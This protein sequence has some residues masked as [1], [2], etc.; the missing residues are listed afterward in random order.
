[1]RK[2]FDHLEKHPLEEVLGQF[3]TVETAPEEPKDPWSERVIEAR[4]G[5]IVSITGTGD[6]VA[7]LVLRHAFQ[8]RQRLAAYPST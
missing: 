5:D 4:E 6:E 8:I 3:R 7:D 1:V 2:L